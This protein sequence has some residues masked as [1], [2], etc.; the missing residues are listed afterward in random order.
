VLLALLWIVVFPVLA[1]LLGT[2]PVASAARH[3]TASPPVIVLLLAAPPALLAGLR[4]ARY[5]P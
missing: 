1:I 4:A 3:G 2:L 5:A